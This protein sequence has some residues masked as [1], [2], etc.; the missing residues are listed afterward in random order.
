MAKTRQ[1]ASYVKDADDVIRYYI[2]SDEPREEAE[3]LDVF[4]HGE[5]WYDQ[6]SQHTRV[7]KDA[8]LSGGDVDAAWDQAAVGDETVGG[9]TATP[10]QDVVE[11]LGDAV[12][13][14][15]DDRESLRPVEKLEKRDQE[16]WEL[17]PAS[18]ED[19]PE[20]SGLVDGARHKKG[21]GS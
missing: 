6:A 15:Y 21:F 5:N 19:Y 20:R 11:E 14:R 10:D 4:G 9:S 1:K 8:V 7:P 18:S 2:E 17:N 16:R 3:E 13:L 12:G